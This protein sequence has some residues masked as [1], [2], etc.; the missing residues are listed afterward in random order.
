MSE[1]F[2]VWRMEF[3]G[4]CFCTYSSAQSGRH[5][6]IFAT[7]GVLSMAYLCAG[8]FES[9]AALPCLPYIP[10]SLTCCELERRLEASECMEEKSWEVKDLSCPSMIALLCQHC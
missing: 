10:L 7:A 1:S 5:R 6:C 4:V 8:E 9:F 3:N 2:S